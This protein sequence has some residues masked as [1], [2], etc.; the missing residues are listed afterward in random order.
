MKDLTAYLTEAIDNIRKD[1]EVTKELL[2]DVIKLN[3][4][5]SKDTTFLDEMVSEYGFSLEDA[6]DIAMSL[7][8]RDGNFNNIINN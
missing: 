4:R 2:D 3:A 8:Q 1:R 7:G 6:S 5:K